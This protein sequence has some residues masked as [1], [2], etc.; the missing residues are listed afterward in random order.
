MTSS[1]ATLN[2]SGT[3][4]NHNASNGYHN[5]STTTTTSSASPNIYRIGGIVFILL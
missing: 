5:N 4:N 1:V 2:L 3:S